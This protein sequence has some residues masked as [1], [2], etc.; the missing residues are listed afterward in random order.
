MESKR[1]FFVAIRWQSL[2]SNQRNRLGGLGNLTKAV[3]AVPQGEV[4]RLKIDGTRMVKKGGK[5]SN[6]N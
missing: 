5:K 4:G 1:V 2:F 3:V 6:T